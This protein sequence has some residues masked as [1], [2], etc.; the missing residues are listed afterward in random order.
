MIRIEKGVHGSWRNCYFLVN[1]SVV[2]PRIRT[3]VSNSAV[4]PR[5]RLGRSPNRKCMIGSAACLR[6][7]RLKEGPW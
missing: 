1:G 3:F 4:E 5:A 7:N 6:P 2:G